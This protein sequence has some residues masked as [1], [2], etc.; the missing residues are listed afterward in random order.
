MTRH[1]IIREA[2]LIADAGMDPMRWLTSSD[3]VE[4]LAM[5][6]VAEVIHDARAEANRG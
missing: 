1:D 5:Q 4:V 6:A 2:S 3:P